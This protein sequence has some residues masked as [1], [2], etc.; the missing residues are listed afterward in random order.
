MLV[1]F[2]AF[3]SDPVPAQSPVVFQNVS[4]NIG[5]AFD[6]LTGTF[7]PPTQG[8]GG[9]YWF[10]FD[11]FTDSTGQADISLSGTPQVGLYMSGLSNSTEVQSRDDFRQVTAGQP[12]IMTSLFNTS[13]MSLCPYAMTW[14]GFKVNNYLV[15]KMTSLL[16]SLYVKR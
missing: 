1:A 4:I 16:E 3:N 12:I 5:N 8:G 7:T 9:L 13:A 15:I 10:H 14:L 11:T 2:Q 6:S